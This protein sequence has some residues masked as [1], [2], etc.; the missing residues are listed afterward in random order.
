L[1]F[2]SQV[3]NARLE[4]RKALMKWKDRQKYLADQELMQR[5]E[6]LA[7]IQGLEE[8]MVKLEDKLRWCHAKEINKQRSFALERAKLENEIERGRERERYLISRER[9]QVMNIG[10]G[11]GK[12]DERRKPEW[13]MKEE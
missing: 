12:E 9:E 3:T 4:H 2:V 6:L 11:G 8:Q 13:K 10:V 1:G 5:N 7:R